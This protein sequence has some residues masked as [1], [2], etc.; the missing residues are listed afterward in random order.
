[1]NDRQRLDAIVSVVC[2]YLP[3]DGISKDQAIGEIISL[4]DPLPKQEQG[5]PVAKRLD[6]DDAWN[7]AK[8]VWN[9]MDRKSMPGIYM[10]LVT[11]SI[12][13]H[14]TTPQQRKPKFKEFIEWAGSQGYDSAHTCNPDTGKWIALN[15]MTADLWKAWKAA[16]GIKE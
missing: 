7:F 8:H 12:V 1:M 2:K 10:Q 4:V 11:E 14:Y 13:K 9:E 3:P 6:P 5:E 16:H 15:P